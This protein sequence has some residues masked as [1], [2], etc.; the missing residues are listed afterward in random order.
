MD[1]NENGFYKRATNT[2]RLA[3]KEVSS[4]VKTLMQG[5]EQ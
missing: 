5:W 1:G 4:L 3:L 2:L